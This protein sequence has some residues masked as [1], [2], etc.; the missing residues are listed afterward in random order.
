MDWRLKSESPEFS[1]IQRI[2]DELTYRFMD[3]REY[4]SAII[5]GRLP[6][7][8]IFED[9]IKFQS[10]YP[11]HPRA[12]D[13]RFVRIKAGDKILNIARN[14]KEPFPDPVLEQMHVALFDCCAAVRLSLSEALQYSGGR[15]SIHY[16]SQLEELEDESELI[17][18]QLAKSIVTLKAKFP[19]E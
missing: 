8:K 14:M 6:K 10:D 7:M 19:S 16:L 3:V 15:S 4:R 9:D 1:E 13:N 12:M 2:L 11:D 5:D 17:K 18:D